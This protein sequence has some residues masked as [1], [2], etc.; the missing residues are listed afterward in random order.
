[1]TEVIAE[2]I[3]LQRVRDLVREIVTE[4]PDTINPVNSIGTCV[5]RQ[6]K[7]G[8][9]ARCIAG[10]LIFRLELPR[11]TAN[12]PFRQVE[13][14][15]YMTLDATNYVTNLQRA[16]DGVSLYGPERRRE[17]RRWAEAFDMTERWLA[18]DKL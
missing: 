12:I 14:A 15:K 9:T 5:Y 3:D 6:L 7:A 17:P 2:L 8:K 1:M 16:A 18:T 11:P 4:Q 10:E 13:A